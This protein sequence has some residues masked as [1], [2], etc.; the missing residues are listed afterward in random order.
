MSRI[1]A[2]PSLPPPLV[3]SAEVVRP[4]VARPAKAGVDGSE[5][6]SGQFAAHAFAQRLP[7]LGR[8]AFRG[9]SVVPG[10]FRKA[11]RNGAVIRGSQFTH[12]ALRP[13]VRSVV[14]GAQRTAPSVAVL[15]EKTSAAIRLRVLVTAYCL[16]GR[17]ATGSYVKDGTVAVDPNVIRLGSRLFIPHYGY[18]YALDTGGAVKG[19]HV[20]EWRASCAD[21]LRA[22]RYETITVWRH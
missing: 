13:G 1:L 17:T 12:V 20:D 6:A 8:P 22:T 16:R 3:A 21:A 7:L 15:V 18:G 11:S 9:E 10:V 5:R 19:R 4:V 14:A 2:P